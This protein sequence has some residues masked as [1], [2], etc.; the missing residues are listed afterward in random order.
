MVLIP[1]LLLLILHNKMAKLTVKKIVII[2]WLVL[3][4]LSKETVIHIHRKMDIKKIA[5][6]KYKI[7][8]KKM[9]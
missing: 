2:A 1:Q 9:K 6:N 5:Y 4:K 8:N 3:E 7:N